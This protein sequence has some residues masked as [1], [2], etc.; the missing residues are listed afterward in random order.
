MQIAK[1]FMKNIVYIIE[2]DQETLTSTAAGY[3]S[4]AF[5]EKFSFYEKEKEVLFLNHAVFGIDNIRFI[6]NEEKSN[7]ELSNKKDGN[8]NNNNNNKNNY[9][10]ITMHFISMGINKFDHFKFSETKL[11]DVSSDN[12]PKYEMPII[13]DIIKYNS[14]AKVIYLK[15]NAIG[16]SSAL[17]GNIATNKNLNILSH[18][19]ILN[20]SLIGV[21]LSQNNLGAIGAKLLCEVIEQNNRIKWLN[22]SSNQ[23]SD[24]GASYLAASL[25]TNN[26][27]KWLELNDNKICAFGI[28]KLSE[29]LMVNQCLKKLE[30]GNNN[31]TDSGVVRIAQMISMNNTLDWLDLCSNKISIVGIKVLFQALSENKVLKYVNLWD[32][33]ATYKEI[34]RIDKLNLIDKEIDY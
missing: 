20:T 11:L 3:S 27:L 31:S 32:N 28:K 6:E 22:I 15:N 29:A 2:M 34:N 16:L 19:L 1:K 17:T 30:I 21:N 25:Q 33:D 10:E 18:N 23:I 7:S 4:F 13:N 9:Y 5:I 24:E 12:F 8:D 14:S 26:S